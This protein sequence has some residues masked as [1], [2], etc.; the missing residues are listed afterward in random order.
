MLDQADAIGLN[1][2]AQK[3]LTDAMAANAAETAQAKETQDR[4]AEST[5][6]AAAAADDASM[7]VHDYVAMLASIPADKR[8]A[9]QAA[10]DRGDLATAE[11]LLNEAARDRTATISVLVRGINIGAQIGAM[12][13]AGAAAGGGTV[14]SQTV[15][16]PLGSQGPAVRRAGAR[17]GSGLVNGARR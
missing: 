12:V 14:V 3:I 9:I 7:S 8:T 2:N 15:F 1:A 10:I 17:F 11:R 5:K 6:G 4:Y 13:R 16:M